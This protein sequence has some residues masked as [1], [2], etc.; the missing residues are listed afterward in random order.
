MPGAGTR[1]TLPISSIRQRDRLVACLLVLTACLLLGNI[2][3]TLIYIDAGST[4]DPASAA[5]DPDLEVAYRFYDAVNAVLRSG[6]T[7]PMAALLA[8]EFVDTSRSNGRTVG[9]TE[10][11][12]GLVRLR[13]LAPELTLRVDDVSMPSARAEVV[14]HLTVAGIGIASFLGLAPP[15]ELAN[16]GWGPVETLRIVDGLVVE[17]WTNAA[18]ATVLKQIAQTTFPRED[19]PS[20]WIVALLRLTLNPRAAILIDNADAARDLLSRPGRSR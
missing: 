8:P 12:D 14:V 16:G 5:A 3:L 18:A 10:L 4:A 6:D 15:A 7:A 13:S 11:L 1:S 19:S 20:Q 2:G 17:R 9:R